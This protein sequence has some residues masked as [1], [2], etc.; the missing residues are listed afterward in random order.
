MIMNYI[1]AGICET[2][3]GSGDAPGCGLPTAGA[4]SSQ[5]HEILQIAFAVLAA[6][7]VLFMVIGGLRM[8]TSQGNPQ[9]TGKARATIIYAVVGLVIAL[10]AEAFVALVLD[11]LS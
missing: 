2:Y 7:A 5:L 11:K 1:F 9:E 4:G 3:S 10:L 6:L 8:V